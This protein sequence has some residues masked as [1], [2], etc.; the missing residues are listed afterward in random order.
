MFF[1]RSDWPLNQWI[2]FTI[3]WFT[4]SSSERARR[5]WTRSERH[6][7]ERIKNGSFASD[8]RCVHISRY[9]IK[10]PW[11][12]V[13]Y[14]HYRSFSAFKRYNMRC[15]FEIFLRKG[16]CNR[17]LLLASRNCCFLCRRDN[18]R[19]RS[20]AVRINTSFLHA[21]LKCLILNVNFSSVLFSPQIFSRYIDVHVHEGY[22]S[23]HRK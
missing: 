5:C 13:W 22:W 11:E 7:G 1:A 23:S 4:S 8:L 15:S 20:N 3:H 16:G 18:F 6:H 19:D 9:A 21:G 2:S 10:I 14:G 12:I 17:R